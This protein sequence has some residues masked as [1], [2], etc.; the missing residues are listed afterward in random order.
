MQ[1]LVAANAQKVLDQVKISQLWQANVN[2]DSEH[3]IGLWK[4]I[5]S[6][7]LLGESVQKMCTKYHWYDNMKNVNCMK[8]KACG[9]KL[10]ADVKSTTKNFLESV[11]QTNATEKNL[12]G[13][14]NWGKMKICKKH[15]HLER[16][17]NLDKDTHCIKNRYKLFLNR[18]SKVLTQWITWCG[19]TLT[20]MSNL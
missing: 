16:I 1:L 14:C 2:I 12:V 20:F 8:T 17:K 11:K 6:Y 5:K 9:T 10:I 19:R 15:R 18:A 13:Q 7:Q 3:Y 4:R